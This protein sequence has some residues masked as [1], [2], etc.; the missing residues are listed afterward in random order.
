VRQQLEITAQYQGY[1]SRQ[2]GEVRQLRE[3]E[4]VTLPS[5]MDYARVGGLSAEI[6]EKLSLSRPVSLGAMGRIPG[7]TPPAMLAVMGH[8]RQMAR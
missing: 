8:L 6:R 4:Q 2:D 7:I 1:L 5:D 3:I